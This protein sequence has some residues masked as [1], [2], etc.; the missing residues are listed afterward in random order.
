LGGIFH[1]IRVTE[2]TLCANS[3]YV[4]ALSPGH[5]LQHVLPK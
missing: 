5:F 4:A 1:T 3:A 2:H